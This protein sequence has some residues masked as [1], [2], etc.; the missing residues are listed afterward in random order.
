MD[1]G[2]KF[3]KLINGYIGT[4]N[5]VTYANN[6]NE[7]NERVSLLYKSCLIEYDKNSTGPIGQKL[8]YFMEE[9]FNDSEEDKMIS[10]EC[11]DFLTNLKSK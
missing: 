9:L 1:N 4:P 2:F 8:D 3:E 6:W 10:I 11:L 5:Y 7:K